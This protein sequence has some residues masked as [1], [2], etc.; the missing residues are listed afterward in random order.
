M[1]SCETTAH[2]MRRHGLVLVTAESCTAGL[3]A[4]NLA[5]IPGA[6]ATL[7]CAYITYSPDAK[8][9][10]LGVPQ[11]TLRRNNLTSEPVAEAM[12][13]GALA[14]SRANVAIADTGVVDDSDPAIPAGTQCLAWAFQLSG[15]EVAVFSTCCRFDGDR[16]EIRE[17]T[18]E[19][20]LERLPHYHRQALLQREQS[21]SSA[22]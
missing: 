16:R 20:A 11:E 6:G 21:L 9:E 22:G 3:I 10:V 7:D 8:R 12:A 2:Y 5:D 17:K 18:A 15:G 13:R 14:R 1:N 4:A 19:H